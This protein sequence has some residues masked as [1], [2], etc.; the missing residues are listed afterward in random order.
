M[1]CRKTFQ[2]ERIIQHKG[3]IHNPENESL[4]VKNCHFNKGREK[5]ENNSKPILTFEQAYA[6]L[7]FAD[8]FYLAY[9]DVPEIIAKFVSGNSAL[10]FGCGG[11]RSTRFL[12]SLGFNTIGVDV[13]DR[14][15]YEAKQ[16]DLD[17]KYKLIKDYSLPFNDRSFDLI[18]SG[19][20]FMEISS[21]DAIIQILNEMKRSLKDE[22]RIIILTSTPEAYSNDW[23][24]FIC[25]FPGNKNLKSGAKAKALLRGTEVE[26]SDYV[27]FDR[28]YLDV[29]DKT[30][31]HLLETH[32][33]L[34]TVNE[35]Y[36]WRSEM[37][38]PLWVIYVLMKTPSK[39]EY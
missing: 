32:K 12:K 9:R 29:F 38:V 21:K 36:G 20:V 26:F 27:W 2:R 16:R 18:F 31:L 23:A 6:E 22:G 19:I 35:L 37:D 10:D 17:G 28:D 30:G 24:S 8:S 34:A 33:P 5:T 1:T 4:L 14:F 25:D 13:N 7:G 39:L 3:G 11:G 15:I